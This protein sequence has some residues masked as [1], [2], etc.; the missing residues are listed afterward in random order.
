MARR[1]EKSNK[2]LIHKLIIAGLIVLV[3]VSFGKGFI[4]NYKLKNELDKLT[5]EMEA[6]E[7]RNKEIRTE[8]ERHQSPEYVE[9]VAR[10]ELGLVRPGE[11]RYIISRPIEE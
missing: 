4:Q 6:L 10:E 3:G 5:Y 2:Y 8:I 1:K 11:T 9:R 7:L